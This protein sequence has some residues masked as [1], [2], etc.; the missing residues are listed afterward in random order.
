MAARKKTAK[1][2]AKKAARTA[3]SKKRKGTRSPAQRAATAKMLAAPARTA[4][5]RKRKKASKRAQAAY[6]KAYPA[7][8]VYGPA[9]L[10]LA[11]YRALERR[12]TSARKRH[13]TAVKRA[14]K[15]AVENITAADVIKGVVPTHVGPT[16]GAGR[17]ARKATKAW[18]CSGPVFSGCGGGKK[19]RKGSRMLEHL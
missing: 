1:K 10:S 16:K 15:K 17:N 11:D 2:V 12:H 3:R 18:V 13:K 7:T 9:L 4:A 8:D 6:A 14:V 19:G 5:P